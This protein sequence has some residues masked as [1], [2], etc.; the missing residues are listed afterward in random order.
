MQLNDGRAL[1]AAAI[2]LVAVPALAYLPPTT[3]THGNPG[4]WSY[5]LADGGPDVHGWFGKD[6]STCNPDGDGFCGCGPSLPQCV[7]FT[8]G[9]IIQDLMSVGIVTV[10]AWHDKCRKAPGLSPTDPRACQYGDLRFSLG[11]QSWDLDCVCRNMPDSPSSNCVRG[12]IQCAKDSGADVTRFHP[13]YWCKEK[14]RTQGIWK[15]ED[16]ERLNEVIQNT[17]SKCWFQY[18]LLR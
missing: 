11:F 13:H 7:G 5:Q 9:R 14:C 2:L 18:P 1:L 6:P 12:C 10:G 16:D 8:D 17:C 4:D 3:G 15:H